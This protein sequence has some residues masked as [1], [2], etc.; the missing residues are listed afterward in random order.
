MSTFSTDK[1][2]LSGQLLTITGSQI[3]LNGLLVGSGIFNGLGTIVNTGQIIYQDIASLSGVA[4]SSFNSTS[5]FTTGFSGRFSIG[6]VVYY[7]WIGCRPIPTYSVISTPSVGTGFLGP[8]GSQTF[9]DFSPYT[10]IKLVVTCCETVSLPVGVA[11]GYCATGYSVNPNDY[12]LIDTNNTVSMVNQ[13]YSVVN[14]GFQPIVATAKSGVYI[15]LL[16]IS[17]ST[18]QASSRYYLGEVHMELL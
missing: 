6:P 10:G 5:G 7:N 17:Y 11:V 18:A 14:S 3:Y 8:T 16:L 9:Y 2:V 1:I 4:S 15:T 13:Q 12:K